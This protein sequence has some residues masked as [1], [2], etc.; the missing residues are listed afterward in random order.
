MSRKTEELDRHIGLR[1]KMRRV[2]LG[3]SQ[4]ELA[5]KLGITF[6]QVQKYEKA[7]NRISAS[8]LYEIAKNLE[9]SFDYFFEG[10]EEGAE[11]TVSE[12]GQSH[13]E[14]I[15]SLPKKKSYTENELISRLLNMPQSPSKQKLLKNIEKEIEASR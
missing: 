2:L 13:D 5:Q 4:D 9:V 3:F 7:M 1:L 12:K 15:A 14:Y 8:R 10:Y 6:Q 11:I